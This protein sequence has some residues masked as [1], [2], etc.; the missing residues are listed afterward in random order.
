[1][2]FQQETTT[3]VPFEEI[4]FQQGTKSFALIQHF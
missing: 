4:K 2:M 3:L 1:M